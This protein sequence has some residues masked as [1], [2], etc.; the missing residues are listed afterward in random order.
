M[1][2]PEEFPDIRFRGTLRPTQA[3][4]VSRA[5]SVLS[6]GE[7]RLHLVAPP[8]SG[9]TILGLYLWAHHVRRPAVVLCPTAAQGLSADMCANCTRV[10]S[11]APAK[12]ACGHVRPPHTLQHARHRTTP[13]ARGGPDLIALRRGQRLGSGQRCGRGQRRLSVADNILVARRS[14]RPCSP[15]TARATQRVEE[16]QSGVRGWTVDR[17]R[18]QYRSLD[19]DGPLQELQLSR[20][21]L[22]G[23]AVR[24]L[25]QLRDIPLEQVVIRSDGEVLTGE[26]LRRRWEEKDNR[27]HPGT[28]E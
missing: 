15:P 19:R 28:N 5:V 27:N 22:T 24:D 18:L 6:R 14:T 21:D 13:I 20:L 17:D 4:A 8:G 2:P 9:K 10:Q 23:S 1:R 3:K 12:S 26:E 11:C 16:V 7:R 25:T